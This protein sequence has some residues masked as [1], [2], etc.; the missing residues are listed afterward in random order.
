MRN[1]KNT[2]ATEGLPEENAS[3][4]YIMRTCNLSA[5]I[6]S[7]AVGY[8]CGFS[9]RRGAPDTDDAVQFSEHDKCLGNIFALCF[10][11]RIGWRALPSNLMPEHK[12]NVQLS[13][14]VG[15]T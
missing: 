4:S 1:S 7:K 9:V 13:I 14:G 3:N 8:G 15:I 6:N 2:T 10:E 12:Q 5:E 11:G